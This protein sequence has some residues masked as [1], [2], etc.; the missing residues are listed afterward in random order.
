MGAPQR[1]PT[2]CNTTSSTLRRGTKAAL[3]AVLLSAQAVVAQ[4]QLRPE[5][6][7]KLA[8]GLQAIALQKTTRSV[9]VRVT[10]PAAFRQWLG[11]HLP[12]A[13]ATQ[14]T[15]A[16]RTLTVANLSGAALAQLAACP[17][18][19]FVDVADRPAH[20]ERQLNNSDLSVNAIAAVHARFPELAG[21]GHTV[22]VKELPFDA[23]DIDFKG[24]VVG[25]NGFPKP[26]SPHA[27][28]MATLIGGAGNS[29][30]QGRGVARQVRLATSNFARLLP[31]EDQQLVPAGISV[32]NHSYGTGIENY[33]GLES[34]DYDRQVRAYPTLLHVFSSGNSGLLTSD[35][36]PYRNIPRVANLT[37]QFK[38]SKN[39]LSVGATGPAGQVDVLSSRGPAYDGRV[40]PEL[41]A[42]GEGGSSESAALVSGISVL[43]HQV[44][45]DQNNGALPSAALVKA[46]LLNSADDIGRPAVDFVSGFGQA[47]ALGAIRTMRNKQYFSETVT[48]GSQQ[49]FTISIP[50]GTAQLKATLAWNDP[51]A[52]ANATGSLVN[53][54]DL[55]VLDLST[56]KEIYPWVLSTF[57]HA[58]SLALPARRGLDRL[59]NVEQ[60]TV[61][62]PAAGTYV[63][64]V[65][66]TSVL[67]GPQ[68]FSLAYEINAP[69]L[70]WTSPPTVGNVRPGAT[71]TLRWQWHG[72]ATAARLEYRPVGAAQWRV[73]NPGVALAENRTA[74]AVPD[75]TTLAQLRLVAGSQVF[76]SDEFAIVRVPPV[77]VGYACP[78]EALLQWA[79][80]PGATQYQVY[81]LGATM[82]EPLLRTADTTLV[83]SRTQLAT[84]H[85]AVAPVLRGQLTEPGSTIDYTTQGTAC[86]FRSFLVRQLV[87]DVVRF[88]VELG[89]VFRLKSATLERMGTGSFEAVQTISPVAQ[90]RFL[91]TD[92]PPAAGRYLYRVRLENL[93]GQLFYS[94]VEEAFLLQSGAAQAYPNPVP[95][96]DVLKLVANTSAAVSIQLF[97]M[98]GKFQRETKVDGVI[99]TIDTQ[100]LKPG[101]YLLRVRLENQAEQ[102]IRVVIQ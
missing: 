101:L 89:S 13:R 48:T 99:N 49:L 10:D 56:G 96:G 81:Q 32:Q 37:G 76:T 8:P 39:T 63:L 47:D 7:A 100:G 55:A 3:L 35:A 70:E 59:N 44:Y 79:R 52:A 40:K 25:A 95:A 11:Q 29:S 66:G 27:T 74:W 5:V 69:G 20:Q 12:A 30:P 97:D 92:V 24:R 77:Q 9:R 54:L 23:T 91:M 72:P 78:D 85:Y 61:N 45:R 87:G 19:S 2:G 86:Y 36:G 73:V 51:E 58:D 16:A 57:P 31:D 15:P 60:V 71:T 98:L 93:A 75:T 26:P 18:V 38:M 34:Q 62:L 84:R 65:R 1:G 88:D 50:A 102:I 67:Q 21:Q 68:A 80:V 42:Y 17:L 83:L 46:V 4:T 94:T 53:D 14:P 64:R 43:L 33:Y 82:L 6:Q 90:T 22:S 41:V 28:D